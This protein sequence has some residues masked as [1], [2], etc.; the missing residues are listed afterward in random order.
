MEIGTQTGDD[1]ESLLQQ[2]RDLQ[3]RLNQ[4]RTHKEAFGDDDSDSS[5]DDDSDDSDDSDDDSDCDGEPDRNG[6]RDRNLVNYY[7]NNNGKWQKEYDD[8]A[9]RLIEPSGPSKTAHGEILRIMSKLYYRWYNDGDSAR[10]FLK[11]YMPM[12][13]RHLAVFNNRDCAAFVEQI[14]S[15]LAALSRTTTGNA[16]DRELEL[17]LDQ[18]IEYVMKIDQS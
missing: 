11:E 3:S 12:Y 14:V 18:V 9:K 10:V 6:D 15:E 5:S 8:L 4:K 2:I 16:Y 7:W 1:R 13:R 17:R